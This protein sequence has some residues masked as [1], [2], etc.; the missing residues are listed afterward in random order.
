[1]T[2]WMWSN[3]LQILKDYY[4]HPKIVYLAKLS[5]LIEEERNFYDINSLK[6]YI[7][8]TKKNTGS[9]PSSWREKWVQQRDHGEVN[10]AIII[11]WQSFTENTN[12]NTKL[13]IMAMINSHISIT[14]INACNSSKRYRIEY[15]YLLSIRNMSVFSK[16]GT[17]L[18]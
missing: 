18:E 14:C 11:E 9:I 15:I 13:N 16:T 4:S 1:M 6:M 17:A 12:D 8:H 5:A 3:A 2:E 7:Q 10:D